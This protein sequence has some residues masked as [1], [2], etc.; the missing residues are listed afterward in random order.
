MPGQRPLRPN[1][2]LCDPA[3]LIII[4]NI[5]NITFA[6]VIIFIITVTYFTIAI[7]I[8]IIIIII[9]NVT[10]I[11]VSI[12]IFVWVW[13]LV[14]LTL[15]EKHRL[16]LRTGAEQNIWTSEGGNGGRLENTA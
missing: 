7:I 14:S 10:V 8:I 9:I 2:A 15:R 16:C 6:I 1:N 12:I 11:I 13:N 5:I 3:H 4:I